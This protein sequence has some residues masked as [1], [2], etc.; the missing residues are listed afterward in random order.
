MLGTGNEYYCHINNYLI[1]WKKLSL[2]IK[3]HLH[4]KFHCKIY[5]FN[6]KFLIMFNLCLCLQLH[7]WALIST[8]FLSYKYVS[9]I[10]ILQINNLHVR[11]K[12][13][14]DH[15]IITGLHIKESYIHINNNK[16]QQPFNYRHL[17]INITEVEIF[18]WNHS[19]LLFFLFVHINSNIYE[20]VKYDYTSFHGYFKIFYTLNFFQ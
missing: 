5:F 6:F 17:K 15:H 14:K 13:I 8:K 1:F 4:S 10:F 3:G 9:L 2:E 20:N 16:N 7:F 11:T 12:S 18:P 19:S